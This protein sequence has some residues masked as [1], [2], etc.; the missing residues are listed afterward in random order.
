MISFVVK[1]TAIRLM[2]PRVYELR[3]KIN[4]FTCLSW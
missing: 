1:A 2:L 3:G 4:G